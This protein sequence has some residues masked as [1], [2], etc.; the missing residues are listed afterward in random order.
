N[1]LRCA[2]GLTPRA[3]QTKPPVAQTKSAPAQIKP[4]DA[5]T[6]S[7]DEAG[8]LGRRRL[9]WRQG[10]DEPVGRRDGRARSIRCIDGAAL[11]TNNGRKL[12][13]ALKLRRCVAAEEGKGIDC[14]GAI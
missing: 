14:T 2:S 10:R 3:A 1:G 11:A 13:M 4:P 9:Y 12:K 6:K 5:Q 8:N 7:P